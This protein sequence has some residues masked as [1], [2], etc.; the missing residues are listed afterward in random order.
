[1]GPLANVLG[2]M[3]GMGKAMKQMRA[4]RTWTTASSIGSRRSSSR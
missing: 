2:M 3:P 1:M 4:G